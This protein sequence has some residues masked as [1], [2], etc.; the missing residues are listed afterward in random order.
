M[1]NEMKSVM[2]FIDGRPFNDVVNEIKGDNW[3]SKEISVGRDV[4]TN[5]VTVMFYST[6]S[7]IE[8]LLHLKYLGEPGYT[9]TRYK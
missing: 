6:D 7:E 5:L 8:I 3:E 4:K 9:F 2:R 1:M